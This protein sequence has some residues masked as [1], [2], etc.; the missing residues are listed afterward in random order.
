MAFATITPRPANAK[1]T[2]CTVSWRTDKADR[3]NQCHIS[4]AAEYLRAMGLD[5]RGRRAV[6]AYCD[7]TNRM[8]VTALPEG[9]AGGYAVTR[10]FWK[11]KANG[12]T[13]ACDLPG[14]VGEQRPALACAIEWDGEHL[15]IAMPEWAWPP[16]ARRAAMAR[17]A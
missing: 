17:A 16:A 7:E 12:G 3:H 8:R 14:I 6:L 13:I 2:G 9:D 10:K 5:A 1:T 11:G 4:I 15:T